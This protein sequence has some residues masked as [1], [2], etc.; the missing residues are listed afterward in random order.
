[1]YCTNTISQNSEKENLSQLLS[2]GYK[3]LDM[4][5]ATEYANNNAKVA[6][7]VPLANIEEYI[8]KLDKYVY[9]NNTKSS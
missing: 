6:M 5:T 4:R 8:D 9:N 1:M 2:S 7:N 3:L